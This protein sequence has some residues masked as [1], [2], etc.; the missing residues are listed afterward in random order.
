MSVIMELKF[1]ATTET[2]FAFN[3]DNLLSSIWSNA[4]INFLDA[5]LVITA[6]AFC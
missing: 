5:F 2:S 1:L 4:L 3:S 6:L